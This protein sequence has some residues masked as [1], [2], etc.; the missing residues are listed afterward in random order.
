MEE[1]AR[2][3]AW[4]QA[5]NAR[6][7]E[8]PKHVFTRVHA[9]YSARL[10][11]VLSRLNGQVEALRGE[12]TSLATRI[13]SLDEQQHRARDERA[14]AE[15]RAHVGELTTEGW[16]EFLAASDSTLA[17][18]TKQHAEATE[19]LRRTREFLSDAER[20]ATPPQSTA[21]VA[22][23]APPAVPASPAPEAKPKAPEPTA[24]IHPHPTSEVRPKPTAS[25]PVQGT[26]RLRP[27]PGREPPPGPPP[28]ADTGEPGARAP[29]AVPDGSPRE[30]G[31]GAAS[32]QNFDELAFLSSIVPEA[33]DTDTAPSS[34]AAAAPPRPPAP[35]PRPSAA[36]PAGSGPAPKPAVPAP[37]PAVPGRNPFAQRAQDKIV[38]TDGAVGPKIDA[39]KVGGRSGLAANVSGNNPIVLRDKSNDAAKTLKC[40]E[41]GAVNYPTEW[42]CERCGAELAS[43]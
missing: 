9:D 40:G 18:L 21:P 38:N 20:P 1:R 42:Y 27:L 3:E 24:T 31:A 30:K 28:M 37:R 22:A 25:V 19:A 7:A 2:Y 29:R 41:C 5:L 4:I 33:P 43:L 35:Q 13:A 12:L 14:E 16:K 39:N 23:V 6:R 17:K 11:A 36:M 10:E 34:S 26:P 15:L 32:G 8:T